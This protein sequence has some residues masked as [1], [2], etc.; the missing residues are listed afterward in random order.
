[1][2]FSSRCFFA[3]EV[4]KWKSLKKIHH[5]ELVKSV[6]KAIWN[7]LD[8]YPEEF[9]DLQKRPNAELS[10]KFSISS[11]RSS[12]RFSI[13][14]IIARNYSNC[15]IRSAKRTDGKFNTFG[16]CR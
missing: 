6:E 16:R 11:D 1:M 8:T 2:N 3:E 14:K 13:E 12:D 7:W 5:T 4:Q 15:S 9:T 10:G